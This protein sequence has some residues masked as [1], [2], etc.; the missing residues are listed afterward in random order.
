M[1]S[2][3]LIDELR[4]QMKQVQERT[5]HVKNDPQNNSKLAFVEFDGEMIFNPKYISI[6]EYLQ[7]VELEKFMKRHPEI[8]NAELSFILNG[9]VFYFR[10]LKRLHDTIPGLA[11]TIK[12]LGANAVAG[13]YVGTQLANVSQYEL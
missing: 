2:Q 10:F 11:Q 6:E 5:Q 13:I 7:I 8:K 1:H 12:A 9:N 4:F 3:D